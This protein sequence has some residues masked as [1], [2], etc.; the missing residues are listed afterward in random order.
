[1]SKSPPEVSRQSHAAGSRRVLTGFQLTSTHGSTPDE[2]T[3]WLPAVVPGGV[4]E[5]LLAAGVLDHPFVDAHETAARWVEERTWWY[6]ADFAAPQDLARGERLH[7]RFACLDTVCD[8]RL[9]GTLIG[10]CR[11]QHLVHVVDVTDHLLPDN[12]LTLQ[13]SPP[14]RDLLD[15]ATAADA[16]ARIRDRREALRPGAAEQPLDELLLPVQ[17]TRLRKA[18]FSWGWDFAPRLPSLGV[19]GEV[20]LERLPSARIAD[21]Q[22]VTTQVDVANRRA[23][24]AVTV[25]IDGHDGSDRVRV[26]VSAPTGAQKEVELAAATRVECRVELDDVELW[27][28]HDL[29]GQP[30]YTVHTSVLT[31]GQERDQRSLR[32]GIRSLELDRSHDPAEGARHFRFLLNGCPVYARGANW[33]PPSMLIGSTAE[34]TRRTLVDLSRDA[35]MTMLRVWGGGVYEPDHFYDACDELGVL[36]WQDFMFACF[37][38]PTDGTDLLEQTEAEARQQ[39]RRLRHHACL[40]LWCGNNEVQGI[41]EITTGSADPGDWGWTIFHELLPA[42]VSE[43]DPAT[44]Y[45]P[46]SPWGEDRTELLN[47]IKDGDRHAWEVWH[48]VDVGAGD[49]TTYPTRG[50][51]VHF[52]RYSR[53]RGRFISEF[54]IHAAPELG[55]LQRWVSEP[56]ELQT[57]AFEHRNKDTPPDKALALMSVE[58]GSPTTIAEYVDFSMACQAEGLKHGVEHYRRRMPHCNGALVWQLNDSWP[59]LSWS[60]IDYDLTPKAAYY[61]LQ[62]AFQPLQASFATADDTLELWVSNTGLA[63]ATVELVVELTDHRHSVLQRAVVTAHVPAYT[64]QPVW[65]GKRPPAARCAWVTASDDRLPRNRQF[66]APIKELGEFGSVTGAAHRRGSD[67]VVELQA[68]GHAYMVRVM[69]SLPG[70]R[71]STNYVDLRQGDI[72]RVSVSGLHPD[73]VLSVAAYGQPAR[74]L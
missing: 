11:N 63:G 31:A 43:L 62:R 50:E 3:E 67:A 2:Q 69:S 26:T 28:T 45:W 60:V 42:V 19:V 41:H 39:V 37:D 27:W 55:T 4:H 7:L 70:A 23:C 10:R 18:A 20:S 49:P 47:G 9:N 30:L 51:A 8:I 44:A 35:G 40:A 12:E 32:V 33:V 1:M 57:P 5:S 59:G 61:F 65:S 14:L 22:V 36:V 72:E 17:R 54:G 48:G 46:G 74:C 34:R 24:L 73:A 21:L 56:L 16:A 29:G 38:Y 71:F 64:S 13:F 68:S 6:R 15:P 25:H 53:D 58:T 52:H 66:L